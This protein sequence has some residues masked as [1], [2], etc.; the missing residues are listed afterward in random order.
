MHTVRWTAQD[1][2]PEVE[3]EAGLTSTCHDL[4]VYSLDGSTTLNLFTARQRLAVIAGATW[5]SL[6]TFAG[7]HQPR[8]SRIAAQEGL[9]RRLLDW[10][11]EWFYA[12]H[13]DIQ[14]SESVLVS[15]MHLQ[16]A[17]FRC[18]VWTDPETFPPD[19]PKSV[20]LMSPS[21]PCFSDL[22]AKVRTGTG[23]WVE[24]ARDT[25]RF[26]TVVRKGG[27]RYLQ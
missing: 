20:G 13:P 21:A 22:R 24:A 17:Y 19:N 15:M 25:L 7:I 2:Q 1:A 9:Q 5:T 6:Y 11:E 8:T 16:F 18:L 27:L 14:F 10:K 26:S 12:A 4:Q 3:T 23:Q